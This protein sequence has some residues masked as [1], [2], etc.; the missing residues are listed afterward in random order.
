MYYSTQD[1]RDRLY[2]SLSVRMRDTVILM[3]AILIASIGL[4]LNST[5]TVIG[6][7]L[8]SPLMAPI[9][10][11]GLA[12]ALYDL[13]LLKKS[14]HLLTVEVA[15]SLV[16]SAIYFFLSPIKVSS[17]EILART[18]PTIWDIVIAIIGGT[19]GVI[20][21]RQK[22]TNNIVPG[23]A[24]ATALM[25]PLCTIAF[26]LVNGHLQLALGA[27]Q[28]FLINTVFIIIATFVGSMLLRKRQRGLV[29]KELD[30]K[31][32]W[33]MLAL[34]T[35]LTIPSFITAGQLVQEHLLREAVTQYIAVEF[36]QQVIIEQNYR[37]RRKRLEITITGKQLSQEE[38][39]QMKRN[40]KKYGLEDI[41]VA[42][43]QLSATGTVSREEIYQYI[44]QILEKSRQSELIEEE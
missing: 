34:I 28:L 6:A 27:T 38:L 32:R 10:G 29:L 21:S 14:L 43:Y 44:D 1:Y 12:L 3:C 35:V 20:G 9:V 30:A 8:I 5:A 16:V 42:I 31:L 18:A 39:D 4:N 2:N 40:R 23:V 25:P 17:P 33:G 15:V 24:I 22:E 13:P 19:A 36:D 26:C 11:I 7:M 37:K 41:Q